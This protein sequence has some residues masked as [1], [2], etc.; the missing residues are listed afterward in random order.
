MDK[1]E[2]CILISNRACGRTYGSGIDCSI[3]T[4]KDF[5]LIK[6]SNIFTGEIK[7]YLLEDD[8]KETLYKVTS[9]MIEKAIEQ[10]CTNQ[11]LDFDEDVEK[12]ILYANKYNDVSFLD[13]VAINII[14][15]VAAFGI[16]LEY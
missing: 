3:P 13:E 7:F 11:E 2:F 16:P 9:K 6:D 14:I 15:Q 5:A 1:K 12:Q 10:I 4:M 8:E